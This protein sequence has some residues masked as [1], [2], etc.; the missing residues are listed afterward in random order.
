M[1]SMDDPAWT[2]GVAL[3]AGRGLPL[4]FVDGDFG[5]PNRELPAS[6]LRELE[7]MFRDG[8]RSTGYEWSGLGD[9][10]DAVAVCRSHG[11]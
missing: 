5:G 11:G 6:R 2:A 10:L 3:A 9:D 1:T 4:V 7:L 8:A